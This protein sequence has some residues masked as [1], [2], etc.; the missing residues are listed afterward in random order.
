MDEILHRLKD[1]NENALAA[2][3]VSKYKD[4]MSPL[5]LKDVEALRNLL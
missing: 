3:D 5:I 2:I 4:S 1:K